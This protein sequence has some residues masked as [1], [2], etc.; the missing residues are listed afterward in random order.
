MS[1]DFRL[2]SL[3]QFAIIAR[4]KNRIPMPVSLA[5]DRAEDRQ[6]FATEERWGFVL[7]LKIGYDLLRERSG[8]YLGVLVAH[9]SSYPR[10]PCSQKFR[11][12]GF[13]FALIPLAPQWHPLRTA[14]LFR[15]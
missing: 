2:D 7:A 4:E 12:R 9:F 3:E 13:F 1:D 10:S 8:A 6:E 14:F 5:I 11:D 15:G